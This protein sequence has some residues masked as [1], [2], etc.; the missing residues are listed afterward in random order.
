MPELM[1]HRVSPGGIIVV[2]TVGGKEGVVHLHRGGFDMIAPFVKV[3]PGKSKPPLLGA[4]GP[5]ADL[6][7]SGHRPA[8]LRAC[9]TTNDPE[10]HRVTLVPI[11][12]RPLQHA[13]PDTIDVVAN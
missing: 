9:P 1:A 5:V 10:R 7:A 11:R 13:V 8:L 12:D 3:E 6:D 4:V 2:L